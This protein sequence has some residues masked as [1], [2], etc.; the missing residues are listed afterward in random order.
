MTKQQVEEKIKEY[1]SRNENL[2]GSIVIVGFV[3][4]KT[5]KK[6]TLQIKLD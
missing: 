2:K 1:L 4:N 5:L 3:C 6:Y